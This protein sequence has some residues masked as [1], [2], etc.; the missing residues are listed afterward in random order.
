MVLVKRLVNEHW[1]VFVKA[2]N[3][4]KNVQGTS[5]HFF[6]ENSEGV[7]SYVAANVAVAIPGVAKPMT[8]CAMAGSQSWTLLLSATVTVNSFKVCLNVFLFEFL[9]GLLYTK[10]I[11]STLGALSTPCERASIKKK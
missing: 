7:N 3:G 11:L 8:Y 4:C 10:A 6:N 2:Y 1:P 5:K 9:H